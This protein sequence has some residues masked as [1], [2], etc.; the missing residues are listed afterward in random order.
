MY[1]SCPARD[2]I[3]VSNNSSLPK[4][5]VR[6][7]E[8]NENRREHLEY[9]SA[10]KCQTQGRGWPRQPPDA[11]PRFW[12]LWK[13]SLLSICILSRE[14]KR[15]GKNRA[16]SLG[17]KAKVSNC[18]TIPRDQSRDK[19]SNPLHSHVQTIPEVICFATYRRITFEALQKRIEE[20]CQRIRTIPGSFER[21][22]ERST[23]RRLV[24]YIRVSRASYRGEFLWDR[25][26]SAAIRRRTFLRVSIIFTTVCWH[27]RVSEHFR[28]RVERKVRPWLSQN[29]IHASII[30][31]QAS[32][33][34]F[35]VRNF[36]F[37]ALYSA[38]HEGTIGRH[39]MAL[40]KNGTAL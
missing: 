36:F 19:F 30:L 22:R 17:K 27:S 7:R 16:W 34:N 24:G 33:L 32:I 6:T 31:P 26:M 12:S 3:F 35:K 9:I 39:L 5:Y 38:H 25:W 13:T 20:A 10:E 21:E 2:F 37:S 4:R 18:D 1:L 14:L 11:A 28:Y 29:W 23:I 8:R 40:L 15:Q